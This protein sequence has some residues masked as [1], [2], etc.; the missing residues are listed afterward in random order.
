M[1]RRVL[2]QKETRGCLDVYIVNSGLRAYLASTTLSHDADLESEWV[3]VCEHATTFD[4]QRIWR[5][6][7]LERARREGDRA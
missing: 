6:N 3:C 2:A 7:I 1:K 5:G 4:K